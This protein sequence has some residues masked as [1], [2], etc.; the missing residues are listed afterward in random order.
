MA[1]RAAPPAGRVKQIIARQRW[2]E[3][4]R[5]IGL[6]MAVD[7]SGCRGGQRAIV[8]AQL[9]RERMLPIED[10]ASQVVGLARLSGMSHM[11]CVDK[12]RHRGQ[13][14][15]DRHACRRASGRR[16][17]YWICSVRDTLGT[18]FAFNAKSM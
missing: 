5:R 3:G 2:R 15:A 8:A 16:R 1:G 7:A 13:Y 18:P 4:S 6:G 10:R 17:H 11:G 12:Q 9:R 14:E